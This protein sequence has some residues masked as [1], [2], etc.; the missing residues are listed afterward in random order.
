MVFLILINA[1][2]PT[3]ISLAMIRRWWKL[4]ILFSS[5]MIETITFGITGSTGIYNI[6]F[7]E[8]F[9]VGIADVSWIG[10]LNMAM[11]MGTGWLFERFI[12]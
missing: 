1:I 7:L 5:F 6:E 10:S 8:H 4:V 11:Y 12:L 9:N 2:T 3:T